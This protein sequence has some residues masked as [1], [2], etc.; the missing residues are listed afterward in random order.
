[1]FRFLF[2]LLAVLLVLAILALILF[3]VLA[4]NREVGSAPPESGMY[5]DTPTQRFFVQAKGPE[6]AQP[7]LLA[8]G[9]AAW[10]GFWAREVE[11]PDEEDEVVALRAHVMMNGVLPEKGVVGGFV[12]AAIGEALVSGKKEDALLKKLIP[13]GENVFSLPSIQCI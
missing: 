11:L 13:S 4:S 7:V 12:G 2:R 10:S 1:M 5:I 3:R 9:T 8:H 6:D